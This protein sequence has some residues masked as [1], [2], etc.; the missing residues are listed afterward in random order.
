NFSFPL[1]AA[2][3]T[4]CDINLGGLISELEYD[5]ELLAGCRDSG[6]VGF[7]GDGAQ[8]SLYKTGLEAIKINKGFG[9]IVYKPRAKDEDI[10]QRIFDAEQA[11][12]KFIGLDIDAAAFLTME[13]M[14]QKV[15][16]KSLDKLQKIVS[17]TKIPFIIKGVMTVYDA[18]KALDCGARAIVVSNHGGR[19]SEN[20]PSSISVL[21][22]IVKEVK[23]KIKI[24]FDGGV[25]SG[26]D[27]FKAIAIGADLVMIGRP[28]SVA[29]VGGGK[30]GVKTLVEN[31]KKELIK[32]MLLTGA[33]NIS[34]INE[35]MVI[36][37]PYFNELEE[38]QIRNNIII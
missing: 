22:K 18:K 35:D 5:T 25:R 28:F 37:P 3:I 9:G 30:E 12:A 7:V 23:G 15:E 4:G 11:G 33:K 29:V 10:F 20:H 6:I 31:Y 2:P 8:P 27:I 14:G 26:E 32:I 21:K 17:K 34:S 16:P 24:I 1:A 13:L 38:S 19:I 36:L